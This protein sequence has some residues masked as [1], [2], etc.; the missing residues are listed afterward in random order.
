MVY[1]GRTA[2]NT[3]IQYMTGSR[4]S[5]AAFSSLISLGKES[6]RVAYANSA[7]QARYRLRLPISS[8][9]LIAAY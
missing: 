7:F 1:S 8:G 6:T 4:P 2:L 5:R 3:L 9:K